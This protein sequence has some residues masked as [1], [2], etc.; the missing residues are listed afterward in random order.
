MFRIVYKSGGAMKN[1]LVVCFLFLL[2]GLLFRPSVTRS[3]EPPIQYIWQ[4]YKANP[5]TYDVAVEPNYVWASY[6]D[7]VIRWHKEDH[8]YRKF[9]FGSR[10]TA[11][12]VA[13]NNH[14]WVGTQNG[15]Y[16]FDG[17]NWTLYN[18]GNGLPSNPVT[19]LG[20]GPQG[21]LLV[22]TVNGIAIFNGTQ[23]TQVPTGVTVDP[24]DCI[25]NDGTNI[26]DI[27]M[28]AQ[29]RVWI[30]VPGWPACYFDHTYWRILIYQG[31]S[32]DADDIKFHPNG[33]MWVAGVGDG[34][35]RLTAG[36]TWITY[37]Q[38]N[39]YP[40]TDSTSLA[41]DN[42]GN[43]WV[44]YT[45]YGLSPG[46][47][48]FDGSSWSNHNIW[49]GFYGGHVTGLAAD[50]AGSI[51]TAGSNVSRLAN[52]TWK[53]YLAG[54]PFAPGGFVQTLHVDASDNVWLGTFRMGAVKFDGHA[55]QH[56]TTA[57]GLGGD[58]VDAITSDQ[59]DNVWF[60]CS[61]ETM[62]GLFGTGLTRFDGA[63]WETFT[64]ADGLADNRIA[65]LAADNDN[66]IWI[67]H[68]Y[69]GVTKKTPSGWSTYTT[70][71][72]LL[73][74]YAGS[75]LVHDGSVWVGHGTSYLSAAG[76]SRFDGTQWTTF[77][78]SNGLIGTVRDLTAERNNSLL[79]LTNA[80]VF[81]FNGTEWV[82]RAVPSMGLQYWRFAIDQ[83]N[84]IWITGNGGGA[85]RFDG[86]QSHLIT[87]NITGTSTLGS[88]V[89]ANGSGNT[90]WFTSTEGVV[91]LTSFEV[92]AQVFL[93]L[94][95]R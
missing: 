27:A 42:A 90:L 73:S 87:S 55:W 12:E 41:I 28:D 35:V 37:N 79:A 63:N 56:Y 92:N 23:W 44:G 48:R 59:A 49:N 2:S 89:T 50:I 61:Y 30:T 9:T 46:V 31:S 16:R 72:G 3:E 86:T 60:G 68:P 85:I 57:N 51:W 4:E 70:A 6:L 94:T 26:S 52:S 54:I 7:G 29:N 47:A 93:P 88:K 11:V 1:C 5:A 38:S 24:Y 65:D 80:G 25:H 45:G 53:T 82:D 8:T 71:N 66:N 77:T 15:L 75:I 33:D 74:N 20:T 34:V 40:S 43:V 67:A 39:G 62:D 19:A 78:Q 83:A 13:I 95:T 84:Q 10:V 58:N 21:Q 18:T 76:A 14:V 69:S 81:Q 36:G 64:T 91:K 32:V 17:A 22:G